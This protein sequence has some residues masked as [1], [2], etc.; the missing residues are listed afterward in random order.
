[1]P[2]LEMYSPGDLCPQVGGNCSKLAYWLQ[3]RGTVCDNPG[4]EPQ[5]KKPASE[6]QESAAYASS[7]GYKFC[8]P[9]VPA[10]GIFCPQAMKSA[11]ELC[12]A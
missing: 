4:W 10:K 8:Q 6:A 9:D 5:Y 3:V 1:M 12:G 7:L 2:P 11:R